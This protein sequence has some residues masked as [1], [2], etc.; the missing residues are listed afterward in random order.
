MQTAV[1]DGKRQNGQPETQRLP[2]GTVAGSL[3]PC[4]TVPGD[5]VA[6]KLRQVPRIEG[7]DSSSDKRPAGNDS[8]G[9]QATA[10]A[11]NSNQRQADNSKQQQ[12][13][14]QAMVNSGGLKR[15][16]GK[17]ECVLQER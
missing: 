8:N 11:T 12:T 4:A 7:G 16:D 15:K 13:N 17:R 10:A 14:N 3:C 5:F 2:A 6:G 1:T 9:K